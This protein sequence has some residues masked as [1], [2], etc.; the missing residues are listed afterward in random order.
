MPP[1]L[2]IAIAVWSDHVP[3]LAP[4]QLTAA[5]VRVRVRGCGH[6]HL[7]A[8]M[9]ATL[10]DPMATTLSMK[11]VQRCFEKE[12]RAFLRDLETLRQQLL[13]K[14]Q[15]ASKATA[16]A[17]AHAVQLKKEIAT[18]QNSL[19]HAEKESAKFQQQFTHTSSLLE[20]ALDQHQENQD[21]IAQLNETERK[22]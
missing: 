11:D 9:D 1:P 13:K 20:T 21:K 17:S 15:S 16:V 6:Y 18:L 2:P 3:P 14:E 22:E 19:E 7:L 10:K 4:V 8:D 5:R 12:R